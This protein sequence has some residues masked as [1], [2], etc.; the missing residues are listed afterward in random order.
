MLYSCEI[1]IQNVV[2]VFKHYLLE[3]QENDKL[4][5]MYRHVIYIYV[6]DPERIEKIYGELNRKFRE[7]CS[8]YLTCGIVL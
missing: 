4:K 6:R 7:V 3:L 5:V 2:R 8:K 1:I